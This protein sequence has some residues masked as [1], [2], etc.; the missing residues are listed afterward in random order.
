MAIVWSS[1]SHWVLGVPYDLITRA[2]RH[3]GQA[4]RDLADIV[5]VNVNRMLSIAGIAGTI[6]TT[7]VFFLLTSLAM[8]GFFYG[9]ELAQAVFLLAFP[10]SIV[11]VVTL[12]TARKIARVQP[13]GDDLI[14]ALFRHR[15]WTQVI[16]M[17]ALFVTAMY[18]MYQNLDVVRGL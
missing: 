3:G 5:R 12:S 10:L 15:V 17:I 7:L 9:F 6:L 8:L 1:V 13:E 18:G 14:S 4:E 2:R 11:G 16:G